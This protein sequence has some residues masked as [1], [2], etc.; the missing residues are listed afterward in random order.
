VNPDGNRVSPL[1]FVEIR[2]GVISRQFAGA[3]DPG[4]AARLAV[5]PDDKLLYTSGAGLA[6][7]L[8][9]V[10]SGKFLREFAFKQN[11]PARPSFSPDGRFI[12]HGSKGE[13]RLWDVRTGKEAGAFE[14]LDQYLCAA[15]SPDGRFLL[16]ADL[17]L[18][19]DSPLRVWDVAGRK[20]V[21]RL[22][23]HSGH[24][25]EAVDI[26]LDGRY[27]V[28]SSRDGTVRV[29]RLPKAEAASTRLLRNLGTTP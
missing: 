5:S 24:G 23:G 17:Q 22:S 14:G 9:D 4:K 21:A 28:S 2:T 29:W 16:T 6:S 10:Q 15:F 8:W 1:V 20:E 3:P 11:G 27:A 26:S 13:V 19:D 12:L 18:G 25:P 7:R